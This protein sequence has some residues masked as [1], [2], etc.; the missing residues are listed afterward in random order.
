MMSSHKG[1]GKL[2]VKKIL[3]SKGGLK[4]VDRV[5]YSAVVL[6]KD[7]QNK[8]LNSFK[9]PEGWQSYAYHMT[10]VFGKG[11][12]DKSEIGKKVELTATELGISDMAMAV[13]VEGYPSANEIPHI[14]IAVNVNEGGKPYDS[15]KINNWGKLDLGYTL[16]LYGK[17]TEIKP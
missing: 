10:I 12:E 9:I 15:N 8:L 14:T 16:K 7:S 13:K 11:L 5:L 4:N 3:E 2:T 1:V 6:D 17:V